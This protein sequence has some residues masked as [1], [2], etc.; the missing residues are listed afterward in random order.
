MLPV[1]IRSIEKN[2]SRAIG[3]GRGRKTN[4]NT[5]RE[6]RTTEVRHKTRKTNKH[7]ERR[8]WEWRKLIAPIEST[9]DAR[10]RVT[11]A[12]TQGKQVHLCKDVINQLCC[13]LFHNKK[14]MSKWLEICVDG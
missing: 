14:K 2:I 6:L 8:V 5:N 10:G 12:R 4:K 1:R 3:V 7:S 13:N 9:F 11:H